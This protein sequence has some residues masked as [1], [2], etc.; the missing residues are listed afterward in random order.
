MRR[1]ALFQLRY[2]P[3]FL[4]VL[5]WYVPEWCA[6]AVPVSLGGFRSFESVLDGDVRERM[7]RA[8]ST[9]DAAVQYD[10]S[11]QSRAEWNATVQ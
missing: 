8:M 11:V 1:R 4:S 9:G 10:A 2:G 5:R 6:V 7:P 3:S